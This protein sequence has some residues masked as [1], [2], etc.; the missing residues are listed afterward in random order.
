MDQSQLLLRPT[1]QSSNHTDVVSSPADSVVRNSTTVSLLSDM[2]QRTEKT[3]SSSR[4]HGVP[5]GEWTDTSRSVKTMSVV[6]STNH[7][8]QLNERLHYF[9]MKVDTQV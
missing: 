2:D 4:T 6:S 3:T 9:H 1:N 5:H 7:H 8:T